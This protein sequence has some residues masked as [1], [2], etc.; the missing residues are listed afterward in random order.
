MYCNFGPNK[1]RGVRSG[2]S[3][4]RK[5]IILYGA[6]YMGQ[7][8]LEKL[9]DEKVYAFSDS[10][11]E[12][13]GKSING[14]RVLSHDE[15]IGG[16]AEILLF[17]AVRS[18]LI[19]DVINSI[20]QIGLADC[21]TFSPC[22]SEI[23]ALYGSYCGVDVEY[24]GK[25]YFGEYASIKNSEIGFG[26]YLSDRT[27][28]DNVKIGKYSAIGP[29]VA[30]VKGKHPSHNFVSIHPAFYSIGGI[31]QPQYAEEQFFSEHSYVEGGRSVIM[32][33]DVWIGAGAKIMEGIH[34]ADGTIVGAGA[35]VTRDTKPYSIVVG[36]PAK[37]ISYRFKKEDIDF[38]LSIK[39]WEQDENWIRNH[40]RYFNDINIFKQNMEIDFN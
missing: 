6:G 15:L 34:I 1:A 17:P 5:K 23:K 9:G 18:R 4:I 36:V 26:S 27:K 37:A 35:L 30:L 2:M 25:N 3:E 8:W 19:E 24:G 39:W 11:K 31:V 16:K 20:K 13:F 14:K 12:I 38:L 32:G 7:K 28:L 22:P 33:N 29:D 21:I 10:N 40:A